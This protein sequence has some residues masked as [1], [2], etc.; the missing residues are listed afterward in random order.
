MTEPFKQWVIEDHFPNGRPRW[1]DAGAQMT[2]NVLPY[3][4]M[5]LRLLNASHQAMAS[6]GRRSSEGSRPDWCKNIL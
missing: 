1:E 3:E 5:K 2:S 4:K 6:N